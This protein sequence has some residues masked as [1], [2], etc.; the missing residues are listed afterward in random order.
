MCTNGTYA[1]KKLFLLSNSAAQKT[2]WDL[3]ISCLN[4]YEAISAYFIYYQMFI[5]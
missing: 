2:K 3:W 5:A 1:P 4:I